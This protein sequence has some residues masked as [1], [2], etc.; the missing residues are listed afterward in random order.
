MHPGAGE[1]DA[2]MIK[3]CGYPSLH[4]VLT[5]S[6]SPVNLNGFALELRFLVIA[7]VKMGSAVATLAILGVVRVRAPRPLVPAE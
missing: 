3:R 1:N 5:C 6:F 7:V 4:V 2:S